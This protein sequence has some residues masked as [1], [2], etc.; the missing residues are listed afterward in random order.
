MF[1]QPD[2]AQPMSRVWGR[3]YPFG[4]PMENRRGLYIY[5]IYNSVIIFKILFGAASCVEMTHFT[6]KSAL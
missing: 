1:E 3:G 5:I 2:W 4:Q 6:F